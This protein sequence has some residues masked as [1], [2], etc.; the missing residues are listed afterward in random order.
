MKSLVM[1]KK[2][3]YKA[4]SQLFDLSLKFVLLWTENTGKM[5]QVPRLLKQFGK[6]RPFA[7]IRSGSSSSAGPTRTQEDLSKYVKEL[8]TKVSIRKINFF[9]RFDITF[10]RIM[11]LV[12]GLIHMTKRQ[13]FLSF[14]S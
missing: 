9:P 13:T 12:T 5:A 8:E 11:A 4:V 14:T 6:L 3:L 1:P 2:T 7:P 10:F